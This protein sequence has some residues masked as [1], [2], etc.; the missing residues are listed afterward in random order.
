LDLGLWKTLMEALAGRDADK[1]REGYNKQDH[2]LSEVEGLEE[3]ANESSTKLKMCG[4]SYKPIFKIKDKQD[5]SKWYKAHIVVKGFLMIPGVDYTESFSPVMTETGVQCVIGLSLH[6]INEDII[7]NLPVEK[8]WI[9]EVYNIE[10]VFWNVKLEGHMYIKISNE[11]VELGFMTK[12]DQEL[13]AIL[14][15]Q[16]MYNN[17][18]AALRFF[19]KYSRILMTDL[20]FMQSQTD[21]CIFFR[22]NEAGR[23][24]IITS[25]HVDDSPISGRRW[26]VEEFFKLF[27]QYL[28]IQRLGQLKKPWSMVGIERRSPNWRDL[29]EGDNSKNDAGDQG[30]LWLCKPLASQQ[31]QLRLWDTQSRQC[32][33]KSMESKEEVKTTQYQSI[34]GKLM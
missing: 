16:N 3:S 8:R 12:K 33:R 1:Q 28:K 18:V 20:G 32:L 21:P 29:L 17:V 26:Q 9:L 23:L 19:K 34:V 14:L 25:T 10:A 30:S 22:C 5:G 24:S 7:L 2:E 27:V 31:D 6:F 11:M 15:D 13:F 4:Y